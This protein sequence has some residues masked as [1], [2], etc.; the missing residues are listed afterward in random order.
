MDFAARRSQLVYENKDILKTVAAKFNVKLDPTL[1]RSMKAETV[2][3]HDQIMKAL[4]ETQVK[5][6]KQ[7]KNKLIEKLFG[8]ILGSP[9]QSSRQLRDLE[10]SEGRN[11]FEKSLRELGKEGE[12][13]KERKGKTEKSSQQLQIELMIS[14]IN[15]NKKSERPVMKKKWRQIFTKLDLKAKPMNLKS[16]GKK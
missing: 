6:K 11:V 4:A 1:Q 13:E 15:G 7:P 2:H 16:I 12:E 8:S 3:T 9:F 5:R 10:L 14:S